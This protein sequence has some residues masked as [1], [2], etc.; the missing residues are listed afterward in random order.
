M[1]ATAGTRN[2]KVLQNT[3]SKSQL[4]TKGSND[5]YNSQ[6]NAKKKKQVD[7]KIGSKTSS[8]FGKSTANAKSGQATPSKE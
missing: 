1:R 6:N 4:A 5:A 2:P 7:P 3:M 8:S